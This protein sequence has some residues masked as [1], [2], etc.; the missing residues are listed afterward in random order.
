LGTNHSPEG[1][2]KINGGHAASIDEDSIR[3]LV[4]SV[5]VRIP[6]QKSPP[7]VGLLTTFD[8]GF[9]NFL[10]FLLRPNAHFGRTSVASAMGPTLSGSVH[11]LI[12]E[13]SCADEFRD[14]MTSCPGITGILVRGHHRF[15][16]RQNGIA[17]ANFRVL[18]AADALYGTIVFYAQKISCRFCAVKINLA[19]GSPVA[20]RDG[21]VFGLPFLRE[22]RFGIKANTA[23]AEKIR[24]RDQIILGSARY[25]NIA[26]PHRLV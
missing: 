15:C 2:P 11:H 16:F 9:L 26:P 24:S 19:G 8:F 10:F 1:S 22:V 13:R 17:P 3:P 7:S 20:C 18:R 21:I 23:I 4:G 5:R 6:R 25:S 12:G 14:L